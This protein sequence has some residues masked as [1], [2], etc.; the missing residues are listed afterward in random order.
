MHDPLPAL[1]PPVRCAHVLTTQTTR[2]RGPG[3]CL[4]LS[5]QKRGLG[6]MM[7]DDDLHDSARTLRPVSQSPPTIPARTL[8]PVSIHPSQVFARTLRKG[9]LQS[10][11]PSS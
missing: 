3:N 5:V 8:G 9:Q 4:D 11:S 10:T 2:L 1:G 6:G 7:M